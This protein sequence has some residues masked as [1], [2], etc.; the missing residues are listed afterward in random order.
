MP[1][2]EIV[3]R[4]ATL[5]NLFL[6]LVNFNVIFVIREQEKVH[7]LASSSSPFYLDRPERDPAGR[8]KEKKKKKAPTRSKHSSSRKYPRKMGERRSCHPT[9]L[10]DFY[11]ALHFGRTVLSTRTGIDVKTRRLDVSCPSFFFLGSGL[12]SASFTRNGS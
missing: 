2:L 1:R 9:F 7:G 5:G 4:P 8:C 11:G 10:A 3:R 12:A 6:C